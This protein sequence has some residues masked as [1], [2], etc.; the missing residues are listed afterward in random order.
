MKGS[1]WADLAKRYWMAMSVCEMRLEGSE[2][3]GVWLRPDGK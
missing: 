3:L 2:L 1:I